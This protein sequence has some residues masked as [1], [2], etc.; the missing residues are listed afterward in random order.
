MMFTIIIYPRPLTDLPQRKKEGERERVVNR[1]SFL[2]GER[3]FQV[4]IKANALINWP[5]K[6]RPHLP[7]STK[8]EGEG[9]GPFWKG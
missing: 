1:E 7:I 8:E 9:K 6:V 5:A 2:E 3:K 4:S